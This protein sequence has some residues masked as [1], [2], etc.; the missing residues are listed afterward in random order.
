MFL[1]HLSDRVDMFEIRK[2]IRLTNPS[3]CLA[4]SRFWVGEEKHCKGNAI[5]K[6]SASCWSPSIVAKPECISQRG[7]ESFFCDKKGKHYVYIYIYIYTCVCLDIRAC[8]Y[9]SRKPQP[10]IE[11]SHMHSEAYLKGTRRYH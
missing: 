7:V 3:E 6:H 10:D 4:R 5:S 8:M 1:E 2:G 9:V 11:K